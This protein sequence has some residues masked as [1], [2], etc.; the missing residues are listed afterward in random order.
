MVA[1]T[2][3]VLLLE[4]EVELQPKRLC[5]E[6]FVK[7]GGAVAHILVAQFVAVKASEWGVR[8]RLSKADLSGAP[9]SIRH[10]EVSRDGAA[11]DGHPREQ[12]ADLQIWW[13]DR[14]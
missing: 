1:I 6:G 3:R 4:H 8:V 12:C 5:A 14:P 11:L 2:Y 7:N 13:R 9:G 10:P